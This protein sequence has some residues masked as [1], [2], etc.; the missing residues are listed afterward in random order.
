MPLEVWLE[1]E[2]ILELDPHHTAQEIDQF[3]EKALAFHAQS[4][5]YEPDERQRQ[6]CRNAAEHLAQGMR[7][8]HLNIRAVMRLSVE[9][10][11][12]L[13][14]HPNYSAAELLDELRMQMR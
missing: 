8:D 2:Q 14:L 5:G 7:S 9:L 1:D 11:D 10:F 3:L 13:Y 6:V 4:Y 12:L